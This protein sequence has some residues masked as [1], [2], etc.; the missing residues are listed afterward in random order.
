ML[1]SSAKIIGAEVLFVMLGKSFIHRR[2]S[3]GPKTEPHWTPCLTLAQL[4][5]LLLLPLLLYIAVFKYLL[6]I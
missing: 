6:S 5:T 2:K 3:S 4:E 1:V